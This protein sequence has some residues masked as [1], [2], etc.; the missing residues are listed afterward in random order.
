MI[1]QYRNHNRG[2][3]HDGIAVTDKDQ[4]RAIESYIQE[5]QSRNH[6]EDKTG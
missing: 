1:T 5:V 3:V 6:V 2:Y 4:Q